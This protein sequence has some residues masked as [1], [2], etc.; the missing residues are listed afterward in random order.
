MTLPFPLPLAPVLIVIQDEAV[1]EAV[2]AH[3]TPA[4]TVMAVPGPPAAGAAKLDGLMDTVH[5]AACVTVCVCP[6]MAIVPVRDPPVFAV[7]E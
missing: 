2:H 5:G 6:A 1:V 3:P 4:V 7:T